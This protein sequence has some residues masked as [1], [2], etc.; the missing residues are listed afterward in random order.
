MHRRRTRQ[1]TSHT[2][3]F[4][5]LRRQCGAL[6]KDGNPSPNLARGSA[7][8]VMFLPTLPTLPAKSLTTTQRSRTATELAVYSQWTRFRATEPTRPRTR[9]GC[10][11][12]IG[13]SYTVAALTSFDVSVL[14]M[15][16]VVCCLTLPMWPDLQELGKFRNF[17]RFPKA[18]M[19][20]QPKTDRRTWQIWCYCLTPFHPASLSVCNEERYVLGVEIKMQHWKSP[21]SSRVRIPTTLLT[22][23]TF[24]S[25][26]CRCD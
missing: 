23:S 15:L 2:E 26:R 1:P 3:Y 22:P 9:L 10:G 20:P 12:A 21:L 14:M 8:L 6:C 16:I 5:S 25:G 4:E 17:T 13:L 24:V 19:R 7:W 18:I 11:S